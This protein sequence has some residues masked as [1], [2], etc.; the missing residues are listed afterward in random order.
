VTVVFAES[1]PPSDRG[2]STQVTVDKSVYPK[3]LPTSGK[4]VAPGLGTS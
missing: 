1:F 3:A 4:L 2:F